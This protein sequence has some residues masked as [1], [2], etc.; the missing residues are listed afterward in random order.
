MLVDIEKIRVEDRI[1][2]DLGDISELAKDIEQNGLINP[3]TVTPDLVLIAGERRLAACK[4]LGWQQIEVKVMEVRDYEHQ[5]RLE[6][7]ENE[8]RKDFTLAERLDWAR[9]LEQV[10]R[11]KAEERMK[12]PRE[13]FPQGEAGKS[14]DK[15]AERL[16]WARRLEQ[17]ERLKAKERMKNPRK[18]FSGGEAGITPRMR[19]QTP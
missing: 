7:S 5:L 12:N 9:R 18:N 4:L 14:R 19:E 10:E 1:R 2:K 6:I 11:L 8:N 13:N 15:V 17:V 3:P 16:D